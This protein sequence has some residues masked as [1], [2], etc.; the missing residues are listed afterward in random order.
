MLMPHITKLQIL[1]SI[2]AWDEEST[3]ETK[4]WF[5]FYYIYIYIYI[6]EYVVVVVL[7]APLLLFPR[8]LLYIYELKNI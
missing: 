4:M 1:I 3:H 2:H 5:Q 8:S 6:M 7:I